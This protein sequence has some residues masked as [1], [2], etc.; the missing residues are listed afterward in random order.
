MKQLPDDTL[1]ALQASGDAVGGLVVLSGLGAWAGLW[2]DARLHSA[3]W[4]V[5]CLSLL[6]MTLALVRIVIK[7]NAADKSASGKGG[8]SGFRSGGWPEDDD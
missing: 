1:K 3:P 6:G 8:A 7:A 4:A 5:T 2:L